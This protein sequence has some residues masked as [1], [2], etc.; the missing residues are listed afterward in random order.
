MGLLAI[1]ALARDNPKYDLLYRKNVETNLDL[2]QQEH[3]FRQVTDHYDYRS[4]RFFDQRYWTY[5]DY[6]NPSIGPIFIYLCG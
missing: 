2:G 4:V 6:Y 5:N 1:F 3:V